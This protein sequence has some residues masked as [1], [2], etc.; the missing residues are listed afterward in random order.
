MT[1]PDGSTPTW[2]HEWAFNQVTS[3]TDELGRGTLY[4]IDPANGNVLEEQQVL[5]TGDD[6][7]TGETDDV[8]RTI[9]YTSAPRQPG[10]RRRGWSPPRRTRSGRI[11]SY[12]YNP[13]SLVGPGITYAVGTADQASVQ[14]E[15][16]AADN[17]AASTDEF[18]SPDH[19]CL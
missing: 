5:G 3:H 17:L 9:S 10:L 15:Y 1:L 7:T 6:R 19:L 11:T 2:T 13:H 18:G 12:Q 14:F 16:D 8:V 4:Q